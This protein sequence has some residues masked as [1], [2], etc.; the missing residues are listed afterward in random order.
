MERDTTILEAGTRDSL[1]P[2][3]MMM[4]MMKQSSP[5]T[6]HDGVWGKEGIAPTHCRPRH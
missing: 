3:M 6:R 5:A 2:W 1:N 4:M